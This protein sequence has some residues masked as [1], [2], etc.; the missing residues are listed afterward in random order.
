[1]ILTM[2]QTGVRTGIKNVDLQR[3]GNSVGHT[4]S[5]SV[6]MPLFNQERF[7]ADAIKCIL[8]QTF[9]DFEL[10]VVDDGST[11]QS[12]RIVESFD[13]SRIRIVRKPHSGFITTLARGYEEARGQLIARMDSDDMCSPER[14][15]HQVRFLEKHLECA[16]VGT[17]YGFTTP[18][19]FCAIPPTRFDWRRIAPADITLG[20]RVFG[21]ATVV[22][23]REL[24]KTVGFYDSDFNNENP[25]WYRLLHVSEGAVLGEPLYLNRW[26]PNSLSRDRATDLS[27]AHV[28]IRAKYDPENTAKMSQKSGFDEGRK[29]MGVLQYGMT[30]FTMAGDRAAARSLS[31]SNWKANPF[32]FMTSKFLLYSILGIRGVRFGKQRTR[33]S[34]T[35]CPS[36]LH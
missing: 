25:L 7:V 26:T 4:P 35:R 14:L 15:E 18:N 24:A 9:T 29:A 36:P 5:V 20:G 22:F 21:D 8:Q 2:E 13:D 33:S 10:V 19:G 30:I 32:S 1:M 12:V 31:W 34:L 11:D 6:V 23:R 3:G 27:E 17:A 16:F 28:R